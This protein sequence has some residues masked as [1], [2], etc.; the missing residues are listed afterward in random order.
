MKTERDIEAAVRD[1]IGHPM[2]GQAD[3]ALKAQYGDLIRET[4]EGI[5]TAFARPRPVDL[6]VAA[7]V[8]AGRT[9]FAVLGRAAEAAAEAA[10]TIAEA[11]PAPAP[12]PAYGTRAIGPRPAGAEPGVASRV[13][14]LKKSAG[15]GARLR[16]ALEAEGTRRDLRVGMEDATGRRLA[17]MELT[18][19]DGESGKMLLDGARYG[20]GEAVLRGLEDGV[21]EL[22]AESGGEVAAFALKVGKAAAANA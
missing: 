17:P 6:A 11:F 7:V 1:A 12:V 8:R 13:V 21:Y 15:G 19:V 16:V 4:G 3:V 18:V 9:V 20:S 5:R 2:A 14:A 22:A 10:G